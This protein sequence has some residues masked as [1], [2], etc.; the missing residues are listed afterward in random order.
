[1]KLKGTVKSFDES[2]GL[3]FITPDDGSKDVFVHFS[4]IQVSTENDGKG[5]VFFLLRAVF[6]L[7]RKRKENV[8][9][10]PADLMCRAM[11]SRL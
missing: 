9:R 1:M 10:A 6:V 2:K 5:A 11:G 4:A 3:G 7:L 8:K